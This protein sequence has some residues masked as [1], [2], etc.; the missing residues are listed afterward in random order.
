MSLLS[1]R[2]ALLAGAVA[3]VAAW[4]AA[5]AHAGVVVDFGFT[6]SGLES[7]SYSPQGAIGDATDINHLG[8][9]SGYSLNSIGGD[10]TTT[11]GDDPT[12]S[13]IFPLI[14]SIHQLEFNPG[15]QPVL[16]GPVTETFTSADGTYSASFGTI[17]APAHAISTN[18]GLVLS[19]TLT[20]PAG[21][22]G[23]T[24]PVFLSMSFTNVDNSN[25]TTTDVSFTETS[26][27]P[28]SISTPEPASMAVL[29][30]ALLG[31]GAVRR[32]RKG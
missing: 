16:D 31:L 24:Q 9:I 13:L 28:P 21:A 2:G 11:I 12:I 32:R 22:G 1:I 14:D 8:T 7:I 26:I 5:P 15:S 17:F 25:T 4:G 23:G 27:P 6:T 3:A 30:M 19:G 10:D 20:L 18:I 29:G